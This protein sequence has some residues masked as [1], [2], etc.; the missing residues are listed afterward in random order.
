MVFIML[1][2][3]VASVA[4]TQNIKNI[5]KISADNDLPK[6]YI[7]AK[8]REELNQYIE[9]NFDDELKNKAIDIV[10]EIISKDLEVNLVALADALELYGYQPIP[11]EKLTFD[12]TRDE[13]DQLLGE[14]WGVVD[15][16][17]TKNLFGDLINKIIDLIRDRL[18]W[19]YQ[20]FTDGIS[21]FKE[22][23]LLIIDFI[24]LP[25]AVIV[26]FIAVVNQILAVPQLL[27]NLIKLLFSLKFSEFIN[28]ILDFLHEFGQDLAS[29]IEAVKQLLSGLIELVDYLSEIQAFIT[30]L[31]DEP[32]KDP[33]L[34]TGTV[35]K[36]MIPLANATITCRGQTTSTDGNG[37]F[38][39]YV[40]STPAND[41]IPPGQWYGMHNC[42]ITVS[43]NGEV[44][45]ESPKLL[46]YAFSGGKI[47][48]VF[49]VWKS[50]SN[51]H[52]FHS[53]IE[54]ILEKIQVFISS[55]QN[56]LN[57]GLF[58]IYAIPWFQ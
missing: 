40:D 14:Y 50:R 51:N 56:T 15:G 47:N 38:S 13:L 27:A 32:W 36:N 5:H 26:A 16:V 37:R 8:E 44:L 35:K 10:N 53:K 20:L 17:F 55:L 11:Q 6:I 52:V 54:Q 45:K 12:I 33:I 25:I 2:L 30:W 18:G 28:T 34:V 43:K 29:M 23:V 24:Q 42:V 4:Q 48:W 9:N 58:R 1:M 22:G 3:P 39:F 19:M 21:L 57:H 49:L 7:T 31:A 46:S 41:S